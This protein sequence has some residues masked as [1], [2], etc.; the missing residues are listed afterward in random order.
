MYLYFKLD[1]VANIQVKLL[2]TNARLEWLN[3]R[4][5]SDFVCFWTETIEL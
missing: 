1:D 3:K 2:R 4:R 5:F